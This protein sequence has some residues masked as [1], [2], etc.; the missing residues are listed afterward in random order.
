MQPE[1]LDHRLNC[2]LRDI[3]T[4]SLIHI[5]MWG[6]MAIIGQVLEAVTL[7]AINISHLAMPILIALSRHTGSPCDVLNIEF[8]LKMIGDSKVLPVNHLLGHR[9]HFISKPKKISLWRDSI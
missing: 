8:A 2:R 9:A 4:S 5:S 3:A 7:F 6:R 1:L